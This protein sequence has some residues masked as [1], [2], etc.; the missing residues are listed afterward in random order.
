MEMEHNSDKCTPEVE[1]P[2][3]RFCIIKLEEVE[4]EAVACSKANDV[5]KKLRCKRKTFVK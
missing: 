5:N 4:P 3:Q 1:V 2:I